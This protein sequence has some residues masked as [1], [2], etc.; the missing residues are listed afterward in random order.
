M[1]Y[2]NIDENDTATIEKMDACVEKVMASG[3]DKDAAIAICDY[4]GVDP[5]NDTECQDVEV[6]LEREGRLV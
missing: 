6:I 2:P 5:E 4:F 1:P 3:K